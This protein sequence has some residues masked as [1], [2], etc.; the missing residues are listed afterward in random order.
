MGNMLLGGSRKAMEMIRWPSASRLPVRR[1][2][3]TPAQRQLSIE[4]FNA[5]KVSV[6]DSGATPSS[7]R[8][9]VYCPRTTFFG[10]IGNM[11]RNTLFFSSLM[12]AGSK[13]VGGSIAMNARIW[14]RCVTTMS[15][16]ASGRLIESGA[17]AEPDG[18]WNV[19]LHMVDEVAVPDRLEQ[20]I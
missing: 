5:M 16:Y 19:D 17:L 10:S 18:L 6:S 14:N 9:P 20:S 11:L 2:N 15:R 8:Y 12:G 3:G 7:D 1:K 13:A 4:H